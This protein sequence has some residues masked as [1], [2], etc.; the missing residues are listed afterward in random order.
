M[1]AV[2]SGTPLQAQPGDAGACILN[3]EGAQDLEAAGRLREARQKA[4]SCSQG[5][6]A[7][8]ARDCTVL[9]ERIGQKVSTV[10]FGAKQDAKDLVD[11]SVS[12]DGQVVAS[13][14]DGKP[15]EIDPGARKVVFT[16]EGASPVE[17][18][19]VFNAA[20]KNRLV[21]VEFNSASGG[22]VKPPPPAAGDADGWSPPALFW[23]LGGVSV[24]SFVTAGVTGG[25]ALSERGDLDACIEVKSCDPDDI[26]S[27]ETKALISDVFIGVGSG[28]AVGAILAL[29]LW[30]DDEEPNAKPTVSLGRDHAWVGLSAEF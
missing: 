12:V 18:R 22:V 3:N 15:I 21:G 14:L 8:I 1:I 5:C 7:E 25:L 27:V 30:P 10:I 11:V 23:I 16:M 29:A 20:E 4:L 28:F 9:A 6:P 2:V 17:V 19:I 26:S 13:R 24:A